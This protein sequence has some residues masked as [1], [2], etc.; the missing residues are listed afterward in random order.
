MVVLLVYLF[1][2]ML[3]WLVVGFWN[4]RNSLEEKIPYVFILFSWILV[5]MSFLIYIAWALYFSWCS[6]VEKYPSIPEK[7]KEF[8]YL[9]ERLFKRKDKNQ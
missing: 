4:A 1:G 8:M 5:I 2:A 7:V 6:L 9:P 3:G